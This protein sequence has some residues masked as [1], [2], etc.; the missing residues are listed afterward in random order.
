V[1]SYSMGSI[2]TMGEHDKRRGVEPSREREA[3]FE[4]QRG[5]FGRRKV[6]CSCA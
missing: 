4:R 5:A 3:G 1:W 2:T 6:E